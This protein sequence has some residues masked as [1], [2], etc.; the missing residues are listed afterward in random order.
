MLQVV[1]GTSEI[2][3]QIVATYIER[4]WSERPK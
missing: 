1:E 3:R 2:Q 4:D